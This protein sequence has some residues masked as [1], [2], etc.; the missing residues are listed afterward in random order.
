MTSTSSSA[1]AGSLTTE[2]A[3][4]AGASSRLS[5]PALTA[6]LVADEDQLFADAICAVL[7]RRGYAV[8]RAGSA[9]ETLRRANELR[10]AITLISLGLAQIV[11]EDGRSLAARVHV[12]VPETVVLA[13]VRSAGGSLLTIASD[14]GIQGVVTA[15]DTV[16]RFLDRIEEALS[17]GRTE[18]RPSSVRATARTSDRGRNAGDLTS[19]ELD[20]LGLLVHSM[21]GREIAERLGISRNTVRSHMQS[22]FQKLHV[23]SRLEAAAFAVKSGIFEPPSKERGVGGERSA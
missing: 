4:R 9:H 19:R 11:G 21:G 8:A 10:P 16:P 12:E 17:Q 20:V 3:R 5:E 18:I 6:I 14:L 15:N 1:Q 23:H 22:I 7:G 2:R 13:M